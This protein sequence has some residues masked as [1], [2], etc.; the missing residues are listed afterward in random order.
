[1]NDLQWFTAL[2]LVAGGFAL[3]M[4][5]ERARLRQQLQGPGEASDC[6]LVRFSNRGAVQ[7][8]REAQELLGQAVE[9]QPWNGNLAEIKHCLDAAWIGLAFSAVEEKSP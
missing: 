3:G 4:I 6:H 7:R 1:M 8:F 9:D 2:L 5:A